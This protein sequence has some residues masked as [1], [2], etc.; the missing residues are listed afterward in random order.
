MLLW[1]GGNVI[2]ST[3]DAKWSANGMDMY[4]CKVFDENTRKTKIQ[5][6]WMPKLPMYVHY[7]MWIS[8]T[9]SKYVSCF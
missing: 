4:V 9:Q 7:T 6:L 2:K 1:I 8:Y 3:K 5:V